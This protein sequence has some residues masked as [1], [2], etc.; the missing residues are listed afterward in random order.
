MGIN[1]PN[2][3]DRIKGKRPLGGDIFI[4]GN[5]VSI[6]CVAITDALIEEV[7]YLSVLAKSNGQAKVPVHIFPFK[8]NSNSLSERLKSNGDQKEFWSQLQPVYTQFEKQKLI[9]KV[10][11]NR[12]AEITTLNNT[13]DQE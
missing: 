9:P 7:Y 2:A 3:S 4:H 8:M 5:C 11:I 12:V 13:R 6:G 1:Y 10:K